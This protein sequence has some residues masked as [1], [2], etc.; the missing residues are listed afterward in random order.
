MYDPKT[1]RAQTQSTIQC[2]SEKI[3]Q[4]NALPQKPAVQI[5]ESSYID[6]GVIVTGIA[7]MTSYLTGN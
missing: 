4:N 6:L 3:Y 1:R 2:N 5:V 7:L